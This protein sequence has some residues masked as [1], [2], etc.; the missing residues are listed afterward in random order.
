MIDRRTFSTA[1][2][3]GIGA[4]ALPERSEA[5]AA[6]R[7]RNVVLVHGLYAD[8]SCWV[9]VIGRLQTAGLRATA[10]QNPLRT[11][12]DDVATT[13][14]L[15]A[16]Q[17]GPT[18]L[19]APLLRRDGCYRGWGSG[20]RRGAGV[21]CGK[22]PDAGENYAALAA[23]FPTSPASAGLVITDGFEQLSEAAFRDDFAN[24]GL[25]AR[26]DLL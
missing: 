6:A 3:G 4:F 22:A 11:F 8:G 18:V 7:I 10:V 20:Q 14:R 24:G 13:R 1:L 2:V 23:R 21:R 25:A 19:V 9:D 26:T 5:Q 16:M 15:L 12:G 17:D